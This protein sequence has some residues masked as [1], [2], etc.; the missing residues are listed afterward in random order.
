MTS[1]VHLD[2]PCG[3]IPDALAHASVV[4]E[5]AK[6]SENTGLGATSAALLTDSS[7]VAQH[8]KERETPPYEPPQLESRD[9]V[10][11][12]QS[13]QEFGW[14]LEAR[15]RTLNF[16]A[17]PRQAF[18]ADGA[19]TNWRIWREHFPAAMPIADFL[20]AL[21]Y[22]WSASAIDEGEATYQKWAQLIWQ[23][24]VVE[25]IEH[26]QTLQAV[27]GKPPDD[28]TSDPR[29][30]VT[31][32]LTYLRNNRDHMDYPTY[33]RQGLPITSAH[34]SSCSIHGCT[35]SGR[36]GRHSTCTPSRRV[37]CTPAT[38]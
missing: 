10:A 31:A 32:A 2:D 27:H 11:S 8:V 29:R 15:A 36:C 28:A 1:E 38:R 14:Q 21:S 18:V 23:G 20:H 4:Q 30:H 26:L 25:V 16:P 34:T 12:G 24:D 6:M 9:V 19:K 7:A 17:A 22:V 37:S 33:R 13:S 5:I 35:S 3:Q